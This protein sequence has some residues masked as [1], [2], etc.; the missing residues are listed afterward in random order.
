MH[1]GTTTLRRHA[2]SFHEDIWK[3]IQA[4]ADVKEPPE[5]PSLE[6]FP[7]S[8]NKN[9]DISIKKEKTSNN[10]ESNDDTVS[11]F[12]FK[13]ALFRNKKFMIDEMTRF[14]QLALSPFF[15]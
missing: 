7:T 3:Q 2:S 10:D 12:L 4:C 11:K 8:K 5:P 9:N 13:K 15:G 6:V 1:G 14:V